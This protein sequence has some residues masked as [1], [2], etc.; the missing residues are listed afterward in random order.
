MGM[1][2]KTVLEPMFDCTQ[3]L[4]HTQLLRNVARALV[5]TTRGCVSDRVA[6]ELDPQGSGQTRAGSVGRGQGGG[7]ARTTAGPSHAGATATTAA[8]AAAATAHSSGSGGPRAGWCGQ[9]C[10]GR[11]RHHRPAHSDSNLPAGCRV[12]A[13]D[14]V[15]LIVDDGGHVQRNGKHDLPEAAWEVV[16][17]DR[18]VDLGERRAGNGVGVWDGVG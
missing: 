17:N 1:Q 5:Q 14:P 18:G 2:K 12:A 13:H 16:P 8:A 11:C 10:W 4:S 6:S 9:Q 7:G 3:H 15:E